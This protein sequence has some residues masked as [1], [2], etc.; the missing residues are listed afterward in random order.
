MHMG[1][2]GVTTSLSVTTARIFVIIVDNIVVSNSYYR[3]IKAFLLDPENH[4]HCVKRAS[5]VTLGEVPDV[6]KY[7]LNTNNP[8]I[9]LLYVLFKLAIDLFLCKC[10]YKSLHS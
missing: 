9:F 2:L 10:E 4:N 8:F 1:N 3:N 5:Q 6:Y 7:A